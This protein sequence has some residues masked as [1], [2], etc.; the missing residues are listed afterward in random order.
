[1]AEVVTPAFVRGNGPNLGCPA[2]R[3]ARS[4]AIPQ[5]Y[6]TGQN[7]PARDQQ[8]RPAAT[9]YP[10]R[11]WHRSACHRFFFIRLLSREAHACRLS[12]IR[13]YGR[14]VNERVKP[15]PGV[16]RYQPEPAGILA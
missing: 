6:H 9:P 13:F 1:M 5:E 2:S 8:C 14:G 7:A 4:A 12:F 11:G 3:I 15:A 10:K 16:S